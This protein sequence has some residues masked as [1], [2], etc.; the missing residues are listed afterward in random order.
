MIQWWSQQPT[1]T[2]WTLWTCQLECPNL[3]L[4]TVISLKCVRQCWLR[5][6]QNYNNNNTMLILSVRDFACSDTDSQ[7]L[8]WITGFFRLRGILWLQTEIQVSVLFADQQKRES[9]GLLPPKRKFLHNLDRQTT[10]TSSFAFKC[11]LFKSWSCQL[12]TIR[13]Q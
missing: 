12:K 10:T 1:A 2:L 13:L 3:L 8:W 7:Y 4:K 6:T 11:K 5:T 9:W